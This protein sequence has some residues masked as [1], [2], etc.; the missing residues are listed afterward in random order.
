LLD[1]HGTQNALQGNGA[2]FST[3]SAT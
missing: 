3:E 2:Q 1:S